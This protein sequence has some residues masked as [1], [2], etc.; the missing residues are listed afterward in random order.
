MKSASG[1]ALILGDDL[2]IYLAAARSLGRAGVEVHLVPSEADDPRLCSRYIAA[3]HDLPHYSGSG[4]AWLAA[5]A[6][7]IDREDFGFVLPCSDD[8]LIRLQ[9]HAEAL[10]RDRLAIANDEALTAFTDKAA[11]RT[12]AARLGIP[13]PSG[14][15]VDRGAE[16]E[17]L[18]ERFGLPLVL[19]PRV[20]Y[21]AGD[22][23]AKSYARVIRSEAALAAA[24]PEAAAAGWLAESYFEGSGV[25]VSVL[26]RDGRIRLAAQHRRLRTLSETGGS[27]VRILEATDPVLLAAA[28]ALAAA[29]RLSGVA[30]F[31]F[32]VD[33]AGGRHVLLEV[34]PRLWGS[35]PLALAAGA[36]F[37]AGLW[38]QVSGTVDDPAPPTRLRTGLVKRNMSGEFERIADEG[39]EAASA[40]ARVRAV[41]DLLRFLPL[42]LVRRGFDSWAADDPGPWRAERRSLLARLREALLKRLRPGRVSSTGPVVRGGT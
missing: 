38:R 31:E 28:E 35:L 17:A 1:R 27:S 40:A 11:T 2:G 12:L 42:L 39:E 25:G 36:D 13:V 34:N 5:L 8:N 7:L 18:I 19:K 16:V 22:V 29:T 15:T 23:Q 9:R 37:P 10:G 41:L 21:R 32:R 26:A 20:S 6:A 30:M 14:A 4:E 33:R 24:L 3:L